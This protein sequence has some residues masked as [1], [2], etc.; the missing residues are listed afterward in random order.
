MSTESINV[1]N[2]TADQEHLSQTLANLDPSEE[3]RILRAR[4]A[5]LECQQTTN[6]STSSASF[7]FVAQDGNEQQQNALHEKVLKLEMYQ[8]EQQ[9]YI[10]DLQ[11][12]VAMLSDTMNGKA[13]IPQQNRW[14][15]AACGKYL[16]ISGPDQ[17]IVQH[18]GEKAGKDRSVLAVEP[19]PKCPFG[20]F[21]YEIKM[22]G[23]EPCSFGL[24]TKRMHLKDKPSFGVGDVVGCGVNL[25]T[26]QIIYTKNGQRLDTADMFLGFNDEELFPC[27]TLSEVGDKIEANFG[28]F[29][30]YKF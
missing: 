9:L 4:I 30:E 23:E 2:I 11:K 21:Y 28:P 27:V 5:Q 22:F 6:S 24:A 13:P 8:K 17:S 18:T 1:D 26:R 19:V 7:D 29:F 10:V 16:V 14:D 15:S 3:L 20:I 25:T 12:T